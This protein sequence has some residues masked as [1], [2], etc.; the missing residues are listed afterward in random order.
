MILSKY[1]G[2]NKFICSTLLRVTLP[3]KIESVWEDN[4]VYVGCSLKHGD[5]RSNIFSTDS[6]YIYTR[7]TCDIPEPTNFVRAWS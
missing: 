5:S 6:R 3:V 1:V 7:N 2:N 4:G